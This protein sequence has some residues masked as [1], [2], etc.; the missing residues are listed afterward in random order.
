MTER[1]QVQ[2]A[3]AAGVVHPTT[4]AQHRRPHHYARNMITYPAPPPPE[5]E[6]GSPPPPPESSTSL[7]SKKTIVLPSVSVERR[8]S[9]ARLWRTVVEGIGEGHRDRS[10][11]ATSGYEGQFAAQKRQ[12]RDRHELRSQCPLVFE[13]T[14][15]TLFQPTGVVSIWTKRLVV[16]RAGRRTRQR[17]A[18][19]CGG[20]LV[21]VIGGSDVCLEKRVW[22]DTPIHAAPLGVVGKASRPPYPSQA[23]LWRSFCAQSARPESEKDPSL[24]S[25]LNSGFM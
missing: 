16:A 9:R 5:T 3:L 24:L 25:I 13:T 20:C 1:N 2:T 18:C 6:T 14:R 15:E 17:D 4:T 19:G 12:I 22:P 10:R 23:S 21:V 11:P 7:D 8:T